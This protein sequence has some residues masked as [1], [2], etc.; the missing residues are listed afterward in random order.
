MVRFASIL[1]IKLYKKKFS[2]PSNIG[3]VYSIKHVNISIYSVL[4]NPIRLVCIPF[5]KFIHCSFVMSCKY[6]Y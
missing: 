4:F 6:L 5:H 3:L 2:T 1:C